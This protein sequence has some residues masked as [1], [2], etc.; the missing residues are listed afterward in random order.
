MRCVR[1]VQ[2]DGEFAEH[3]AVAQRKLNLAFEKAWVSAALAVSGG[4][5]DSEATG[6]ASPARQSL[7]LCHLVPSAFERID[8][9]RS[10]VILLVFRK[11]TLCEIPVIVSRNRANHVS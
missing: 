2:Q 8:N 10:S 1:L 7:L 11:A 6:V 3:G 4:R 5:R 9:F